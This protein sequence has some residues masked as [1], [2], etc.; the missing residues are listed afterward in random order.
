MTCQSCGAP[1][2]DFVTCR[3]CGRRP[4]GELDTTADLELMTDPDLVEA[5]RHARRQSDLLT[6][7][8]ATDLMQELEMPLQTSEL[9]LERIEP[10]LPE[11]SEAL[12]ELEGLFAERV[13]NHPQ[14]LTLAALMDHPGEQLKI[15]KTGLL[16]LR[17]SRH[18]E[19]AEWWSLQRSA[20]PPDRERF[21]LMLLLLQALAW[22]LAGQAER[23]RRCRQ[24]ATQHPAY[25]AYANRLAPRLR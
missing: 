25:A 17:R 15:V 18:A 5:T 21:N 6:N 12:A 11:P 8:L 3:A 9:R 19:A 14:G 20:L 23:A 7:A 16:F 24:Q 10:A 1:T 2:G 13:D 4:Y 22:D